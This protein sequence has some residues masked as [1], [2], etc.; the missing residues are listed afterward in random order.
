[1]QKLKA[2]T[3]DN[4]VDGTPALNPIPE[5]GVDAGQRAIGFCACWG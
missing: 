2:S 1:M 4:V 3:A 5:L